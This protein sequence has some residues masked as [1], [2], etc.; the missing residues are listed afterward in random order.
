[1]ADVINSMRT[2]SSLSELSTR[3]RHYFDLR[4]VRSLPTIQWPEFVS[5]SVQ[6][7]SM[8]LHRRCYCDG[9]GP[10]YETSVCMAYPFADSVPSLQ[11][12]AFA[13]A[14]GRCCAASN[15]SERCRQP[16]MFVHRKAMSV[17]LSV[18][19]RKCENLIEIGTFL[20][21]RL[22]THH[23]RTGRCAATAHIVIGHFVHIKLALIGHSAVVALLA[24]CVR[25]WSAIESK[26]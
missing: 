3:R 12:V 20:K 19:R 9:R 11:S 25:S 14:F 13:M 21:S 8:G 16:A 5:L 2:T 18:S 4:K 26:C 24:K 7:Q 10:L 23:I 22:A 1:M 6:M 15:Q 17:D